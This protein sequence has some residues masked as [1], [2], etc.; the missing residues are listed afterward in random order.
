MWVPVV[1]TERCGRAALHRKSSNAAWQSRGSSWDIEFLESAI[2]LAL[3]PTVAAGS[4]VV[5]IERV[6]IYGVSC[7][8]SA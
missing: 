3:P 5:W 4:N 6:I 2:A 7:C 8:C 1:F